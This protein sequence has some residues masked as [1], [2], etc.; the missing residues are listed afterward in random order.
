MVV[1]TYKPRNFE[2]TKVLSPQK[3]LEQL[4][5]EVK[6]ASHPAR[7]RLALTKFLQ[8]IYQNKNLLVMPSYTRLADYEEIH[9]LALQDTILVVSQKIDTYQS[10]KPILAWIKG[11]FKHK[12]YD[13]LKK[14]KPNKIQCFS[15]DDLNSGI[16]PTAKNDSTDNL[17]DFLRE[18]P[19]NILRNTTVHNRPEITL[20]KLL[21]LIL[22]E[23]LSWEVI[24]K[25]LNSSISTLSSFY[26]RNIQKY[27]VYFEKYLS[28]NYTSNN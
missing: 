18:D 26:Q 22:I 12:F 6:K 17:A 8:A 3:L 13:A 11:I 25:K 27:K 14:N 2:S 4:I 7:K 5:E 28:E 1:S 20:Q 21:W 15:L 16:V 9:D 19:E 24:A 10:G 23:D